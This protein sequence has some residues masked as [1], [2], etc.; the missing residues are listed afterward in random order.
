[1]HSKI[2]SLESN[3]EFLRTRPNVPVHSVQGRMQD[4]Q[5]GGAQPLGG[6]INLRYCER[7]RREPFFGGSG[8]MLPQEIFGNMSKNKQF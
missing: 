2:N 7:R 3:V 6:C 1:M 5:I 8:G 4:L